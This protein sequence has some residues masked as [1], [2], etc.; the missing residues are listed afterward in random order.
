LSFEDRDGG[1]VGDEIEI[2]II[3]GFGGME[4]SHSTGETYL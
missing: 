1:W 4:K 3:S 2:N